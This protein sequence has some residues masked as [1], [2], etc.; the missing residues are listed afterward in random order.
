M[1]LQGNTRISEEQTCQYQ[2]FPPCTN[3]VKPGHLRC[4]K[5]LHGSDDTRPMNSLGQNKSGKRVKD[6]RKR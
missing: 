6:N 4:A 1:P 2:G 3:K 5:H